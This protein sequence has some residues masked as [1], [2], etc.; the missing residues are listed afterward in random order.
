MDNNAKKAL[1][2]IKMEI[3][4][5][6]EMHPEN[7]FDLIECAYNGGIPKM[8]LRLKRSKEKRSFSKSGHLE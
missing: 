2:Q 4:A 7:I 6:H 8:K 3:A 1:K 5:E